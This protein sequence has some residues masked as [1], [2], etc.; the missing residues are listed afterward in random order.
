MKSYNLHNN[1]NINQQNWQILKCPMCGKQKLK[2]IQALE[3]DIE[4]ECEICNYRFCQGK[5]LQDN[6]LI[7][8]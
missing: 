6:E 3:R 4:W 2:F 1:E 8:K 7:K 5:I